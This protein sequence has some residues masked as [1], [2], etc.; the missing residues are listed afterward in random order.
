MSPDV[1]IE[2][3]FRR[4][5]EGGRSSSVLG[6]QF[7]CPMVISGEM[8]D[9]RLLIGDRTLELGEPYEVP[10]KFLNPQVAMSRLEPGC[11][12]ALW[13]GKVVADGKVL[14]IGA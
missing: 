4:C 10:V 13:E 12:I 8:F 7:G 11:A 6:Q 9:C 1:T 3:R 5:S 14:R 2:V